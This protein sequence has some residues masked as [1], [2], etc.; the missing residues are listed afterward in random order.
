[1]TAAQSD[2]S[3]VLR[4]GLLS[5]LAVVL[6][7]VEGEGSASAIGDALRELGATVHGC[8]LVCSGDP[9]ADDAR[10]QEALAG[11]LGEP[12][13]VQALV[14]DAA[15]LF[16]REARGP[17]SLIASLEA[18]WRVT[19][20]V[21]SGAFIASGGGGR[22]VYLA[23]ATAPAGP[24]AP[25]GGPAVGEHAEA[26]RAGLENLARTLSIEWARYGVTPVSIAPGPRTAVSELAGVVAYLLSPA[27]AYLSGTELDLRGV[28]S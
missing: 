6:A 13:G 3:R 26:A 28:G 27:G 9:E 4:P 23:P 18:A 2:I 8:E 15:A 14:L 21:A 12:N 22:V 24:R 5:G 11:A 16:A 25:A 10:V 7:G 19:R 20:A 1:M 17:G